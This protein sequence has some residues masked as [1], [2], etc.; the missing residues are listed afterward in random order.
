[1]LALRSCLNKKSGAETVIFDEID[2]GVS[3]S[4]SERIGHLLKKISANSQVIA[5][6]H[7]PQ[8]A[9]LADHHFLIKKTEIDGRAESSVTLLDDEERI[10][11][12]ARIIGGI[13]VTD[14]QRAAAREMLYAK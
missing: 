5:I 9:A 14:K 10:E 11:E 12:I 13:D 2:A 1:M 3:G 7:S 8:I 4:T 6:T